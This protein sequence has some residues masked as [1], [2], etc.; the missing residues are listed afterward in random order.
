MFAGHKILHL[1]GVAHCENIRVAG[2]H[3]VID[4]DAAALADSDTCG[5][6]QLGVGAHADGENH[7]IGRV[8]IAL[9]RLNLDG[10]A[11]KLFEAVH[12]VIGDHLDAVAF[13]VALHQTADLR[14]K[15]C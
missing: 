1:D 7:H 8:C 15:W 11:F 14:V 10:T 3:L 4:E 13:D 2:V 5:V 9:S 12:T 6:G